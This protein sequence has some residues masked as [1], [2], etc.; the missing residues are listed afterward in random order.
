MSECL[1]DFKHE[2]IW[3]QHHYDSDIQRLIAFEM[4]RANDLRER[5]VTLRTKGYWQ[6]EP[7][8]PRPPIYRPPLPATDK[9]KPIGGTNIEPRRTAE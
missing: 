1:M 3:C 9:T 5:E 4:R 7:P 8:T 2:H 6:E